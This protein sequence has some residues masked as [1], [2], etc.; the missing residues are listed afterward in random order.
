M[1]NYN[2]VDESLNLHEKSEGLAGGWGCF[3]LFRKELLFVFSPLQL[4]KVHFSSSNP[5]E[6]GEK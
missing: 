3:I 2:E 6:I 4:G 1:K 5:S